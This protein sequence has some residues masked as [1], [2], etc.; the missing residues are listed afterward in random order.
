MLS[1]LLRAKLAV[2]L[3]AGA[4]GFGGLAA[5][6]YT[7]ALPDGLQD[8]AHTTVG[9]PVAEPDEAEDVDAAADRTEITDPGET[10]KEKAD[11]SIKKAWVGPD[12]TGPAAFGLCTAWEHVQASPGSAA[13]KSVAFRNLATAAGGVNG[14][15]AYCATIPHPGADAVDK[16]TTH[17]VKPSKAAKLSSHPIGK[18][19]S[20]PISKSSRPG[21]KPEGGL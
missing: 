11:D 5:A 12:A 4:V 7:G 13:D 2:A 10:A 6:A 8:L 21:G 14:I 19:G 1:S 3:A 17:P 9:T 16:P 15:T 20:H 18:P